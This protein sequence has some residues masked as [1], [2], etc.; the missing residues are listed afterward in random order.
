MCI[1]CGREACEE[2]FEIITKL[3]GPSAQ[4]A[5]AP[6]RTQKEKQA[7]LN[8]FF[9]SCARKS[10]HG[11]SS[12]TPV[13]R[14]EKAELDEAVA[15]MKKLSLNDTGTMASN[16]SI[17]E[18]H[19]RDGFPMNSDP[20]PSPHYL[21]SGDAFATTTVSSDPFDDQSYNDG[22]CTLIKDPTPPEVTGPGAVPLDSPIPTYPIPRYT[23]TSLTEEVFT[24]QWANG[25][26]LVVSGLLSHLQVQWTPQYF[27]SKYGGQ[28]CIILECQNDSNKKVTV[29]EFFQ[30]FGRY[31]GRTECWKL[32]VSL[33]VNFVEG[34]HLRLTTH[35][36]YLRIGLLQRTSRPLFLSSTKTSIVLFPFPTTVDVMVL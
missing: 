2:C 36:F 9:L 24:K 25:I 12:F 3:T 19:A 35:D 13:T 32:K 4:A 5:N 10:E 8:P 34:S 29:E 16:G 20:A 23:T 26:P 17:N 27:T 6:Q 30:E 31:D 15:E 14:F 18:E 33:T 1:N 21:T 7:L 28:Q 22:V 11:Y